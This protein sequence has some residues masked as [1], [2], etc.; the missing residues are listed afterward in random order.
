MA[1]NNIPRNT[2]ATMYNAWFKK[3]YPELFECEIQQIVEDC[4]AC[5]FCSTTLSAPQKQERPE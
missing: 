1:E 3:E 4:T 2:A 5:Q